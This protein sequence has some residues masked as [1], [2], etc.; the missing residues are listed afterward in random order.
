M[1]RFTL[2]VKHD[3]GFVTI[4]TVARDEATARYLVCRAERCPERAIR[5]VYAG[6]VLAFA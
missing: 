2:R 4:R 5:R 6:K 3:A 1:R